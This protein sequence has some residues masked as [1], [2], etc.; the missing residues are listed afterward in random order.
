MLFVLPL[1]YDDLVVP[2]RKNCPEA[3]N[4]PN[5]AGVTPEDLLNWCKHKEVIE[6]IKYKVFD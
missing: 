1:A 4:A 6:D 2:L 5:C 3:M